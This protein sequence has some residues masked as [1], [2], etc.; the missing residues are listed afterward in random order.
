MFSEYSRT[1]WLWSGGNTRD[2]GQKKPSLLIPNQGPGKVTLTLLSAHQQGQGAATLA[3]HVAL[4]HSQGVGTPPCCKPF[5][6]AGSSHPGTW[7]LG[8]KCNPVQ[9]L[10]LLD[11]ATRSS[12]SIHSKWT[13][14]VF[15]WG[16]TACHSYSNIYSLSDS[17]GWVV[18]FK[19]C[20]IES[21]NIRI[22]KNALK[23][24]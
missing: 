9:P 14:Q 6:R 15:W 20:K 3:L 22:L 1:T 13:C 18:A 7:W 21:R 19:H 2:R 24:S 11:S 16:M 8:Y 23:T 4:F 5:N 12:K 17:V 10:V